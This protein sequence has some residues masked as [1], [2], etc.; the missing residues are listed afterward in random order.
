MNNDFLNVFIQDLKDT[1]TVLQQL[2]VC[3]DKIKLILSK[4]NRVYYHNIEIQDTQEEGTYFWRFTVPSTSQDAITDKEE[5]IEL[6]KE[7]CVRYITN[8]D[9]VAARNGIHSMFNIFVNYNTNVIG[10]S[11][12]IDGEAVSIDMGNVLRV[13]DVVK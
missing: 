9:C 8:S 2:Q 10:A 1:T 5:L 6:L 3:I 12:I 4:M 13:A 11:A 7:T